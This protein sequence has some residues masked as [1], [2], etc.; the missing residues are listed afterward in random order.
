[1]A[2]EL[3]HSSNEMGE[4]QTELSQNHAGSGTVVSRNT[5]AT[6]ASEHFAEL[7]PEAAVQPG[8][9]EGVAT[10]R[11]HGAQVTEQLDEQKVA[12][13]DEVDVDVA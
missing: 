7:S 1:M 2:P 9:E 6:A 11:A 10:G 3:K 4:T 12:L 5:D 8:V 13:V